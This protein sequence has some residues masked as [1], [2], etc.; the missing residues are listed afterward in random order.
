MAP[1]PEYRQEV[2]PPLGQEPQQPLAYQA[3]VR[4]RRLRWWIAIPVFLVG[5]FVFAILWA[6]FVA[7]TLVLALVVLL[8]SP[9]VYVVLRRRVVLARGTGGRAVSLKLERRTGP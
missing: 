9:I 5:A 7:V 1:E 8:L 3:F 2:L 4:L 6:L